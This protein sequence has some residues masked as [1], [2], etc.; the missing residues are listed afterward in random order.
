MNMLTTVAELM[1]TKLITVS[2][3]TP[4]VELKELFEKHSI[5][6]LPVVTPEGRLEGMVSQTDFI[7]VAEQDISSLKTALIMTK[8]LAKLESSDSLRTAASVFS[9]NKFHALP[10]VDDET[11]VGIITT[12]D[13]IKL[14]N[15][16]K[17]DLTDYK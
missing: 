17:I 16:E 6:H 9:L 12:H 7:K 15:E 2:P 3:H 14:M 13:L 5:H 8:K 4:L 1:T 11:L 10:V